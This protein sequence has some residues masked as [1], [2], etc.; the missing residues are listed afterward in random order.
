MFKK[1]LFQ[2][3]CLTKYE[4]EKQFNNLFRETDKN[5]YEYENLSEKEKEYA[6]TSAKSDLRKFL[7]ILKDMNPIKITKDMKLD[8]MYIDKILRLTSLFEKKDYVSV[9]H[10][11]NELYHFHY[12]LQPQIL[13]NI[14]D[15]LNYYIEES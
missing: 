14:I 8:R 4:I 15:L 6:Q 5:F 13:Y 10:R 3:Q 1:I 12:I 11:M 9:C 2:K 7:F